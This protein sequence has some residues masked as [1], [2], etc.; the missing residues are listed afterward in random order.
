[1]D[2]SLLPF[3]CVSPFP[4]PL[5]P[6]LITPRQLHPTATP[7]VNSSSPH[8]YS[9]AQAIFQQPTLASQLLTRFSTA[10]RAAFKALKTSQE[11]TLGERVVPKGKSLEELILVNKAVDEKNASEILEAVMA[12]LE[13]QSRSVL[14]YHC[15]GLAAHFFLFFSYPV[16]LAVDDVQ[17]IFTTSSY[18]D[19]SYLPLES[20]S[21]AIPR[22]LLDFISGSKSFVRP[23][24]FSPPLSYTPTNLLAVPEIRLR[25]PLSLPPLP[26]PQPRPHF[27]LQIPKRPRHSPF[28]FGTPQTRAFGLRP[29]RKR[30]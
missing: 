9:P 8:S 23:L 30:V 4:R 26:P 19:P 2:R 6:W 29:P 15:F 1:M 24:L 21:L 10:N 11:W 16:L 18:I 28:R 14:A 25:P 13:G 3:R 27:L 17:S 7:L 5:S 20:F 12:E 22:L